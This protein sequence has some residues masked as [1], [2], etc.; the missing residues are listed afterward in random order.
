M[1]PHDTHAIKGRDVVHAF[2]R[3]IVFPSDS[4]SETGRT[5][6]VLPPH[7]ERQ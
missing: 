2:D 6:A 4:F 7:H 5:G 1:T 3:N